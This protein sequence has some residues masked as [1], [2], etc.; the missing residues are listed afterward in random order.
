MFLLLTAF[1][2][3]ATRFRKDPW[4][5]GRTGKHLPQ[6]QP[7]RGKPRLPPP[8]KPKWAVDIFIGELIK[9]I[10]EDKRSISG[11]HIY[12]FL[13]TF[14]CSSQKYIYIYIYMCDEFTYVEHV[15]YIYRYNLFVCNYVYTYVF[16]CA[17]V[18]TCFCSSANFCWHAWEQN[19]EKP[20]TPRWCD[21]SI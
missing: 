4:I 18:H 21:P 17:H 15:Y 2:I 14:A 13:F 20:G 16:S 19:P 8:L 1:L 6:T 5:Y 12:T 10:S 7:E 11:L 3:N 9:L